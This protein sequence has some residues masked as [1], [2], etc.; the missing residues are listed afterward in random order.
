MYTINL[1]VFVNGTFIRLI[2]FDGEI[3]DPRSYRWEISIESH[4]F[5]LSMLLVYETAI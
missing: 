1:F 3:E 5:M 4:K 2:K